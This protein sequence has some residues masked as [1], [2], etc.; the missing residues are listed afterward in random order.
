M[1]KNYQLRIDTDY[2]NLKVNPSILDT[3]Q[4]E[5]NNLERALPV[6]STQINFKFH[7]QNIDFKRYSKSGC[8]K[9]LMVKHNRN[10]I[11]QHPLLTVHNS[12]L[13]L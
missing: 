1:L 12:W 5:A 8:D 3:C 7:G 9:V 13:F 2:N 10:L 11:I 6:S 4:A